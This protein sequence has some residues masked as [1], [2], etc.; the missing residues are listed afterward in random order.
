[1]DLNEQ[2][3]HFIKSLSKINDFSQAF[4]LVRSAVLIKYDMHRAGLCLVLQVMPNNLGAYHIL[5]S[6]IIVVNRYV[7][8]A[9]KQMAKS[10]EQYNSYLFMVLA[11]E[12][13]HSFGIV[14]EQRVRM[15]TLELCRSLFGDEHAATKMAQSDP[16]SIFPQLR[17]LPFKGFE[18]GFEIIRNFDTRNQSYIQ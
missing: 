10:T 6:N 7:L 8:T 3:S 14:D 11:H 4:E 15:M 12:Y 13:L 16:A 2:Q 1:M 5:G 17:N 18:R 9:I